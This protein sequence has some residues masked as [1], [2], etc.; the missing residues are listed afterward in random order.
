MVSLVDDHNLVTERSSADTPNE[1]SKNATTEP[2]NRINQIRRSEIQRLSRIQIRAKIRQRLDSLNRSLRRTHKRPPATIT[3]PK[4]TLTRRK[5]SNSE[6]DSDSDTV[7]INLDKRA[8]A[9]V[10]Q[11]CRIIL[12]RYPKLD[13]LARLQFENIS[14][15]RSSDETTV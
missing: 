15:N 12:E 8:R 14:P 9:W 13:R 6:S 1:K 11:P 7:A 3:K 4:L 10:L 2:S 5:E